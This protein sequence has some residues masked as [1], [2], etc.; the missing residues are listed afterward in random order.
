MAFISYDYCIVCRDKAR[1]VNGRCMPCAKKKEEDDLK[2]EDEELKKEK[3][4]SDKWMAQSREERIR[5]L[6]LRLRRLERAAKKTRKED[7]RY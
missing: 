1:H 2:K 6:D 3:E 5:N 7:I 4:A